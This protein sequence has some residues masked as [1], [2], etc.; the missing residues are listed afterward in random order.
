ML[1]CKGLHGLI[2]AN[3]VSRWSPTSSPCSVLSSHPP[4]TQQGHRWCLR[5][6]A[7]AVLTAWHNC[8]SLQGLPPSPSRFSGTDSEKPS[9]P[10]CS[11]VLSLHSL[12]LP[13]TMPES[14]SLGS[15]YRKWLGYAWA[16]LF[17][18]CL[19]NENV[20]FIKGWACHGNSTTQS[21]SPHW[22]LQLS[23]AQ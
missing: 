20:S 15:T 3:L 1:V 6:S 13:I 7:L 22:H 4:K 23:L 11:W 5:A 10:T 9:L 16:Q 18:I 21:T 12:A 8:P 2:F 17:I 14:T 19:I